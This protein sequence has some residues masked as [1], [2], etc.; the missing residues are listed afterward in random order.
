VMQMFSGG[1]VS[2]HRALHCSQCS[3]SCSQSVPSSK[4][5]KGNDVPSVPSLS[6]SQKILG[7]FTKD[8]SD[9][10]GNSGNTGNI[11]RK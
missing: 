5:R 9:P 6:A 10:T 1:V 8:F 2:I 3:Q 4:L 7:E 11:A